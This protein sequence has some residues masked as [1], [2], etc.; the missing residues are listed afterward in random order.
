MLRFTILVATL[1]TLLGAAKSSADEVDFSKQ[2]Q[3]IFMKN[4]SGCHGEKKGLGGLR[5]HTPEGIQKKWDKDDHL[6]VKGKPN[7]SELYERLLLP[8]DH[9]KFMPKKGKPLAKEHLTLIRDWISQGAA[10]SVAAEAKLEAKPSAESDAAPAEKQPQAVIEDLPLPEVDAADPAT[11]ETLIGTG[12]Q[13][14]SLFA[15][16]PLLQVSYALRGEPATDADLAPLVAV[17]S[18]VYSLNLAKAQVSD[19]G[20]A[21]VSQLNN[22]SRLHLE[23]SSVADS[24][25]THLSSLE[26]LQYL[27]L[28][29]TQ[30]TDAGLAHLA[31]LKH[32]QKLYVWQTKVS[33]DAAKALE[34]SHAGLVVDLGFDHPVVKRKR[35]TSQLKQANEYSKEAEADFKKAKATFDRAKQDQE[36]LKKRQADLQAELDKLDGKTAPE[37][38]TE[39]KATDDQAKPKDDQAKKDDKV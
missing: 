32:L 16:S 38:K 33:Y 39:E 12:A 29:G 6:I 14:T 31:S 7:E 18:Q 25:L 4:C 37:E 1:A 10:F 2:I 30:L 19:K 24:G 8:T 11:I 28:Y 17:A 23:N 15:G 22:L 3:P 5:L 35:L 9:K 20:L 21:V 34:K 36:K 26:R 13:V 27:N